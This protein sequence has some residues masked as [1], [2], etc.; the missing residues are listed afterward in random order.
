MKWTAQLI[1]VDGELGLEIPKEILD[2]WKV[3]EGDNIYIKPTSNGFLLSPS[4]IET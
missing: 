1:E 3:K 4:P 2:N